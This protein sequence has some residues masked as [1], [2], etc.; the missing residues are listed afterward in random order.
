MDFRERCDFGWIVGY[1]Y[2]DVC[3]HCTPQ[4]QYFLLKKMVYPDHSSK[5]A[6]VADLPC[7]FATPLLATPNFEKKT[8]K[9]DTLKS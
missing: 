6:S 3:L 9:P 4:D 8:V 5:R 2:A 7:R 1:H